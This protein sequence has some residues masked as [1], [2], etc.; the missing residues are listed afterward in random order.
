MRIA[1]TYNLQLSVSEDE[2]EFD[3]PET[4]AA[5]AQAMRRLGH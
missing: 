2:A 3:S 1:Y 4:V 5:L